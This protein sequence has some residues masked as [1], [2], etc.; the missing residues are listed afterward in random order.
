MYVLNKVLTG[1]EVGL[2]VELCL[3]S[4]IHHVHVHLQY[5]LTLCAN[6]L[7]FVITSSVSDIKDSYMYIFLN[8]AIDFF[9]NL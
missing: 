9:L 7:K 6:M 3:G 5:I 2:I 1:V 8:T 4:L